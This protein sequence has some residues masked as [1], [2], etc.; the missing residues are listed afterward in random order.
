MMRI[1]EFVYYLFW[2]G[3]LIGALHLADVRPWMEWFAL[4][5]C[6]ILIGISVWFFASYSRT[7]RG[8]RE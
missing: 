8:W 5:I 7:Q 6:P 3:V 4:V 1:I 2:V